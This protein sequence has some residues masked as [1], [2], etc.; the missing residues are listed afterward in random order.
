MKRT[1][2]NQR[3]VTLVELIVTTA[4][5]SIIALTMANFMANW[6]QQNAI[7]QARVDLL[8]TAQNA[9]DMTGNDIRLSGAA[10]QNNRWQDQNAPG[11]PGN[12]L[13]WASGS[14]TLI[15]AT[16]AEGADGNIIFSDPVHYIST[17]NNQ[18]YFVSGGTLYRRTLAAPDASNSAKT[19]CPAN[20]SSVSCPK[21]RVV[22]TGVTSFNVQYF[23]SDSQQVAPSDAR[24]IEL[25]I[26]L[27]EVKYDKH[28]AASYDTRMVFRND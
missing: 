28:I 24:S 25:K 15:L 13:S 18:I 7:S 26:T 8:T 12:L 3:G 27:G 4:V 21:D 11:A 22:A 6:L 23:N 1:S 16:A 14:N 19:T 17:K 5:V 10:D 2:L 20:I 9:L